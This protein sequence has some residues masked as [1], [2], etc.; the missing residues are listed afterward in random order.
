MSV[1]EGMGFEAGSA[2]GDCLFWC[3]RLEKGAG[4]G[5]HGTKNGL[6]LILDHIEA[7]G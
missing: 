4:G 6:N 7:A 5:S 3:T 2:A 1:N